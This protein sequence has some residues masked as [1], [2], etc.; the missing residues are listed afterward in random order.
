MASIYT[1]DDSPFFWIR[2][3]DLN[4]SWKGKATG[5][6]LDN[7]GDRRQAQLLADKMS[8]EERERAAAGGNDRWDSWVDGWLV[9]KYGHNESTTLT[10][11]RRYWKYIR[12]WM[13][14]CDVLSPAQFVYQT[15]LDYRKD[16][17][18]E[19]SINQVIH[20]MKFM[21]ILMKEAMTRGFTKLNP[22]S[23]LGW[24]SEPKTEKNP[25]E[26]DAVAKV[27]EN[28]HTQP[29]WMVASFILGYYQAARLRQCEVPLKDISIP[30]KRITYWRSLAGRPLTKGNKPFTHPI[31]TA[32]LPLLEDLIEK[33]R[34]AGHASLC[35]I[36]TP[37]PSVYWRRFLD[38]MTLPHLCQHGLRTT[39]ITQ[40]AMSGTISQAQAKRFV[41]HGSTAVHAIYQRLSAEDIAHVGDALHLPSFEPQAR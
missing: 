40:A 20:E 11:F 28:I 7:P 1:R 17:E 38:S 21:G 39:W 23:K 29:D 26:P 12:R 6:R 13:V 30:R 8:V 34:A 16:R 32:A 14:A 4:G 5:Y 33:R 3:K 18:E 35:D 27:A 15:V 31:A 10:V 36:D 22:C 37:I 9:D 2:F 41:N 24:K 25:W 19:V